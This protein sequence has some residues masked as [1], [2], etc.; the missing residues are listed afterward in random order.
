MSEVNWLSQATYDRLTQ[1]L[2]ELTTVKRHEIVA[3]IE[4]ARAEGDLSENGGYHAAR[5]EQSKLETRVK[6]LEELLRTAT[7]GEDPKD[8]GVVRPGTIVTYQIKGREFTRYLGSPEA[9]ADVDVQIVS[10]T[11]PLGEAMMDKKEGDEF[12]YEAND[13]T[14]DAKILSVKTP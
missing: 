10:F 2:E 12:S 7:V 6:Q 9:A 8:D 4:A 14:F 3:R 5:E 13:K 11:S 1:E